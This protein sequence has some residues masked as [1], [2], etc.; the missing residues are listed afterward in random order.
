MPTSYRVI[1][2]KTAADDLDAIFDYIKEHSPQNAVLM[3]NKILAAID[4]LEE[5]PFRNPSAGRSRKTGA[6]IRKVIVRPFLAYYRIEEQH[7][8]VTILCVRH[9][10][11]RQ[12]RKFD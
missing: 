8:A 2:T 7:R 9:G 4:G 12:P 5:L 6:E 11:Q 3:I 10:A 1:I